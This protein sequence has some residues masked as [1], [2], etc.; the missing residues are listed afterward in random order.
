MLGSKESAHL[1]TERVCRPLVR[2]EAPR[3]CTDAEASARPHAE[4][5]AAPGAAT[6]R[7]ALPNGAAAAG[8]GGAAPDPRPADLGTR[9]HDPAAAG[10]RVRLRAVQGAAR[11][12]ATADSSFYSPDS[13]AAGSPFARAPL[14]STLIYFAIF[15][16]R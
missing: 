6:A 5:G 9:A 16:W 4:S 7:D 12:P 11:E 2:L 1:N 8:S 10:L 15:Y 3:G 13:S 14:L